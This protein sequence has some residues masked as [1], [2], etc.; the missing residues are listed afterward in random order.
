MANIITPWGYDVIVPDDDAQTLPGLLTPADIEA[1]SRGRIMASDPRVAL[2]IAAVSAAVRDYCG[3]H[4]APVL[5]CQIETEAQDGIIYLPA[6]VVRAVAYVRVRDALLQ[7][8][9]YGLKRN[10]MV[11]LYG[12]S[13]MVPKWGDYEVEYSAGYDDATSIVKQVATQIALNALAA[14]PGV[15]SESAGQVS[16]SYNQTGDGITGGVSLLGRDLAILKPYRLYRLR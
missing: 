5:T 11:R 1:A 15:R 13:L 7:P 12:G 9:E 4:V 2:M 6:N 10:G 14:T 16:L 3:W 8:G